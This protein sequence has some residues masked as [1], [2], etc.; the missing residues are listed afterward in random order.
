MAVTIGNWRMRYKYKTNTGTSGEPVWSEEKAKY[1]TP[2]ADSWR[3]ERLDE[4]VKVW[5]SYE[6]DAATNKYNEVGEVTSEL[7]DHYSTM[8]EAS[9]KQVQGGSTE[10]GAAN[11]TK[12]MFVNT[13]G[14]PKNIE[15]IYTTLDPLLPGVTG[16][17][18]KLQIRDMLPK[19]TGAPEEERGFAKEAYER[20]VYGISKEAGK[21]GA[22]MGQAYG[23]MGTSMRG[24][25]GG[26]KDVSQQFEQAGQAY[27]E[28]IYGLEKRAGADFEADV[29]NWLDPSWFETPT[30]DTAQTTAWEGK[31]GGKVPTFSETLSKLPEAGG[32]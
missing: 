10:W 26:M 32:S 8:Q 19:Y 23:G 6:W 31:Q 16:E 18:L 30:G 29:G 27:E 5:K 1:G 9:A 20:D 3:I 13:D 21:V 7:P 17:Q 28:D 11:I 12:D 22:Q 15:E 4:G 2:P 25:V 24:A 14:T